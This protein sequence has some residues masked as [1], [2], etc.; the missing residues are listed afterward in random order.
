[1]PVRFDETAFKRHPERSMCALTVLDDSDPDITY[2]DQGVSRLA[3]L[4]QHRLQTEYFGKTDGRQRLEAIVAR[5]KKEGAGKDYDCIIGVSGGVDSTYIAYLIKELGLRALAVHLDNGWD[6]ELAQANI[7]RTVSKLGID[8][9]TY[10]VDWAEI[11]DLQRAYFRASL[12]DIEVITDHA[13]NAVLFREAAKRNIRFIVPGSNVTTESIM[14]TTYAYDQRDLRNLLAVHRRF[15]EMKLRTYPRL[16][17]A[18]L[19]YCIFVKR[20]KFVPFLNYVPYEK[21]EVL[22]LLQRELGYVPYPRK[23]GESRFTR[24]FQE[25]YLPAKFNVDKRK[26]HYS[27][28]IVSGQ[29]SREE[30][31]AELNKPLYRP[32]ELEEEIEYVADKLSFS[33]KEFEEI[34]AAPPKKHTDYPNQA[35][36]FD[37][38]SPLLQFV[39]RF[40]KHEAG[41]GVQAAAVPAQ[42]EPSH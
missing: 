33:R 34:L 41:P 21:A 14:P 24:F 37:H 6:T 36:L 28:L 7:E 16:S 29:M 23:H 8:L 11:R 31:L 20:I 26:A 4:A 42:V 39:R 15:G 27:S 30:A 10:V 38:R 9:S 13:I 19:L 1:M 5:M 17:A 40:A 12:L 35:W 3:R 22:A 18:G 32:D 2:D 25:H